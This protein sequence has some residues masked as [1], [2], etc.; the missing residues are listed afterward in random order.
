VMGGGFQFKSVTK[1]GLRDRHVDSGFKLSGFCGGG[2]AAASDEREI[3]AYMGGV[4]GRTS[5]DD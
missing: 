5:I 1:K 4:D 2:G 3:R